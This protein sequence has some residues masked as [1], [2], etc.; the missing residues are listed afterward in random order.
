[1]PVIK[2]LAEMELAGFRISRIEVLN[3]KEK[4][5]TAKEVLEGKAYALARQKF[6]LS[7]SVVVSKAST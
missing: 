5:E 3:F 6:S 4:L 1:M 2:C 7:S